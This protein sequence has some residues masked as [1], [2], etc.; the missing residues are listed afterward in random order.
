MKFRDYIFQDWDASGD[1]EKCRNALFLFRIAQWL[2]QRHA[3]WPTL[4]FP[5][6]VFYRVLVEWLLCIELRRTTQVGA[7]LTLHHGM[8][9]VVNDRTVIGDDCVL[10]HHTTIGNQ[11]SGGGCPRIGDRVNIGAHCVI[12]GEI[13]IGDDAVIGAGSIVVKDVA[14]RTVV[15]GNP[16]REIRKE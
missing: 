10:R 2:T 11:T 9:L 13:T 12:L 3:P 8:G 16:S 4:A 15:A 5:Y 7:R 14:P 1:D 6:F